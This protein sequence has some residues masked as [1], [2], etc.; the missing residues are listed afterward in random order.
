MT[1]NMLALGSCSPSA[2]VCRVPVQP[3]AE[4]CGCP[5]LSWPTMKFT[6]TLEQS[7]VP[8]SGSVTVTLNGMAAPKS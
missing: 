5:W 6:F 4:V 3:V 8:S 2:S 7:I 1:P